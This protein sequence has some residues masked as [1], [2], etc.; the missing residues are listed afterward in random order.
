M[1]DITFAP[2]TDPASLGQRWRALEAQ[3]SCGFFRG[4]SYLGTLLPHFSAPHLLA[5]RQDGR[6]LALGLFNR[7]RRGLFLHETGEPLWDRLYVEHNGLLLHPDGTPHLAAALAAAS[8]YG[9]VALSGID[10][11]HHAAATQAGTLQTRKTHV[12]P[13]LDLA[14]LATAGAPHLD[15]LSA[16]ARA[17]IRRAMRLYGP[18][19]VLQDAATLED[20]QAFFRRLVTLHQAS[21]TA[22]GEPGAFASPAIIDFHG[23]LIATGFP[24]GEV[25]LLRIHAAGQDIGILYQFQHGGDML[26]YQSGFAPVGDARLKPGLVCHSLA[27]AHAQRTGMSTYDFLAGAQRYKTTL[28]PG[29]GQT[30]HWVTLHRP[31]SVKARL[32]AM[33]RWVGK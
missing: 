18:D 25:A 31:G 3:A 19:L 28:A 24:R 15:T 9:A 13:A 27:I 29:G 22:R 2:V 33:R 6:D 10:T 5:I 26:A 1:P 30:L 4:W 7:T 23:A 14:A 16:N 21:W 8:A 12:A 20:A 32:H 17:Q 11:P